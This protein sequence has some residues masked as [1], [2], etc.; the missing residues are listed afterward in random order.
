M[1]STRGCE[2]ELICLAGDIATTI[3]HSVGTIAMGF[4][5]DPMIGGRPLNAKA[6]RGWLAGHKCWRDTQ[7]QR[8]ESAPEDR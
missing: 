5:D 2:A 8:Q 4:P 1:Y 7:R 6:Q 3:L